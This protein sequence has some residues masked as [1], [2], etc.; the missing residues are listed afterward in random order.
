MPDPTTLHPLQGELVT[1]EIVGL[2]IHKTQA[3]VKKS[4]PSAYF[5]VSDIPALAKEIDRAVAPRLARERH[6]AKKFIADYVRNI[7]E[8]PEQWQQLDPDALARNVEELEI[9]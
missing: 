6:Q 9:K 5:V 3:S 8:T 2:A 4:D 7:A 1:R